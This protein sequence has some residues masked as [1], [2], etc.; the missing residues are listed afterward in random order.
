ME[1]DKE[2]DTKD[3]VDDNDSDKGGEQLKNEDT[4]REPSEAIRKLRNSKTKEPKYKK[5]SVKFNAKKLLDWGMKIPNPGTIALP[6]TI[7]I[8]L[9]FIIVRVNGKTRLNWLY[10]VVIGKAGLV[11]KNPNTGSTVP[12]YSIAIKN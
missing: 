1:H 4:P 10:E 7:L 8:I 5:G 3:K 11:N 2:N 9:F 12:V 6:L